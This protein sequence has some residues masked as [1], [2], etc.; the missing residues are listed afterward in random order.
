MPKNHW[1]FAC[2][3]GVL[4]LLPALAI[5]QA[6][7]GAGSNPPPAAAAPAPPVGVEMPSVR[8]LDTKAGY[9]FWVALF[10]FGGLVCVSCF[11]NPKRSHNN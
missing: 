6:G 1:V 3:L 8:G 4:G 9:W 5:G 7:S 10:G 11:K 2:A